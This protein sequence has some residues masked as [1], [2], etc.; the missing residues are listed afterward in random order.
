ML[1][2]RW[3]PFS[4]LTRE[5]GTIHREM[6]ELFR[7]TFGL[8][9]EA[10]HEA[11]FYMTPAVN[12]YTKENTYVV[13]AELPGVH[14]DDLDVSIE[15]HILTLKGERKTSKE[16]KEDDYYIRESQ[17]GSFVRKLTLPEGVN[18]EHI[19]AKFED[20]ILFVSMPIEKKLTAGR[21][22]LIEGTTEGKKEKKVH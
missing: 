15:G 11:G 4:N 12:T 22:V 8:T 14:K 1:P 13:E 2:I 9:K 19:H 7:R 5:L 3:D 6:D 21:K 16:T 20:G 18:T 10:P 17:Y